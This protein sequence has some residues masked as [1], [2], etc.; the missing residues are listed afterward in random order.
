MGRRLAIPAD[1]LK[2]VM[3]AADYS[4][5]V[6]AEILGIHATALSRMLNS[7][8]LSPWWTAKKSKLSKERRRARNA[9]WRANRKKRDEVLAHSDVAFGFMVRP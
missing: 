6:A 5:L 3:Q 8:T 1:E 2:K 7:K 9:R 4:V